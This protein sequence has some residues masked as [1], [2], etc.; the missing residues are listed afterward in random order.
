MRPSTT[1][2]ID[3]AQQV[4]QLH[5]VDAQGKTGLHK[6]LARQQVLP[7]LAQWPP[8]LVGLEACGGSHSWARDITQLGHTVQ[9]MAPPAVKPSV[10]GHKTDGRD[11]EGMGEAASRPRGR[12]GPMHSTAAQARPTLPRIREPWVK[13]RTALAQQ[14]RG[15]LGE[16]GLVI[17]QGIGQV[18]QA[19]PWIVEEAANGLRALGRELL[20]DG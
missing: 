8:C 16:Y 1:L 17:P 20:W 14:L 4:F 3:T 15:W 12:A 7:R 11:A 6:R 10:Q 18:R 5:G 13:M 19:I 2:G 9:R